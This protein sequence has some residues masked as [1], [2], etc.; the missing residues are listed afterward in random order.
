[1]RRAGR[2]RYEAS[3]T[4]EKL[5]NEGLFVGAKRPIPEHRGR[6]L[7][8]SLGPRLRRADLLRRPQPVHARGVYPAR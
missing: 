4:Q 1:M 6:S 3:E 5:G 7:V 2:G 8:T